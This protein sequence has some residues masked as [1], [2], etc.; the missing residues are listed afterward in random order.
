MP[1]IELFVKDPYDELLSVALGGSSRADYGEALK[2][3]SVDSSPAKLTDSLSRWFQKKDQQP[4][5]PAVKP[6]EVSE[7]PGSVRLKVQFHKPLAMNPQPVLWGE[8]PAA[9]NQ[10][11]ADAERPP[12]V[13]GYTELFIE[14]EDGALQDEEENIRHVNGRLSL[15]VEHGIEFEESV[16]SL[17]ER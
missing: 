9:L 6:A 17:K 13:E 7:S 14:E 16:K 4:H 2:A 11:A 12:S 8:Q 10:Q 5:Q 3:L 15:Q 1:D